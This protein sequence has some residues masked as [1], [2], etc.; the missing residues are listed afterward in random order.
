MNLFEYIDV[1]NQ[2]YDIF[3]SDGR[4]HSLHWHYYSEIVFVLKGNI[5]IRNNTQEITLNPGDFGFIYPLKLHEILNGSQDAASYVVLKFDIHTLNIPQAYTTQLNSF[6]SSRESSND[7]CFIIHSETFNDNSVRTYIMDSLYEY[8]NKND[9]YAYQIQLNISSLLIKIARILTDTNKAAVPMTTP[10]GPDFFHILE[11][12]D[13][14]SGENLKVQNLAKMCNM[15][16]SHFARLFRETYGRSCK[17][18][19]NYIRVNKAQEL[20]IHTDYDLNYVALETGFFD[21]S[22]FIRTYKKYTGET[23][24][25]KRHHQE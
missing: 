1:L 21:C 7:I 23:P 9:F 13:S 24:S 3:V 25:Q 6:F 18:Y 16:Y 2:P 19:I 4:Y 12:I 20:L 5:V 22:H 15:S 11:Y 17:D 8:Q 10:S 14:H